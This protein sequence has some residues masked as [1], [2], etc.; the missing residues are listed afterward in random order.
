MRGTE[1]V[2]WVLAEVECVLGETLFM[3]FRALLRRSQCVYVADVV[4]FVALIC[5]VLNAQLRTC[6]FLSD[7][8]GSY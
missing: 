1:E 4:V 5:G 7:F 8:V 6:N 2:G 3:L